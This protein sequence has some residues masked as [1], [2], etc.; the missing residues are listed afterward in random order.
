MKSVIRRALSRLHAYRRAFLL[1]LIWLGTTTLCVYLD[2]G[3]QLRSAEQIALGERFEAYSDYY[4][5]LRS[6]AKKQ[7]VLVPMSDESFDPD[8]GKLEGPP[9]SRDKHAKVV[10]DLVRAGAKAVVFDMVFDSAKS[11]DE[12]GQFFDAVRESKR[13][14]WGCLYENPNAPHFVGPHARFAKSGAKVGHIDQHLTRGR[15]DTM[16]A[17]EAPLVDGKPTKPIASLSLHGA[18]LIAKTSDFSGLALDENGEFRITFW[19]DANAASGHDFFPSV[20]YEDV[21]A[22]IDNDRFLHERQ[23]FKD[24]IVIIGDVTTLG[25]DFRNTPIADQM[26]GMEIQ[27]HATVTVLAALQK[28]ARPI[29]DAPN[30]INILAIALGAALACRIVGAWRW[31]P[32]VPGL[33]VVLLVFGAFNVWL[34]AAHSL[35]VHIISPALAVALAALFTF[36]ERAMLEEREKNRVTGHWQRHVDPEVARFILKYPDQLAMGELRDA[37]VLF[38]DIR[39]FTRLS[40]ELPP[41][42]TLLLLNEYLG[43]MTGVVKRHGGTLDKYVGD[44]VMAVFGLPMPYPDHALRAVQAA[45]EM[46]SAFAALRARWQDE[47]WHER[48]LPDFDIGIGINTGGM[49]CGELGGGEGAHRRSDFTVIGD[50]VNVAAHIESLTKEFKTRLLIGEAT[51]EATREWIE[52]RGP[53]KAVIKHGRSIAVFDE[54]RLRAEPGTAPKASPKPTPS[55]Q[56]S[57]AGAKISRPSS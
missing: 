43:T 1:A 48:G 38:A 28:G 11:G 6:W 17:F 44:A 57:K 21:L 30:W 4:G 13:V 42:Q 9:V 26:A 5:D 34:F 18:G 16:R 49:L 36:A 46:Q 56:S 8:G 25:N 54:V 47:S 51:F 12:D 22:G 40:S 10:R 24:K 29:Q 23:F 39:G 35:L 37:T 15:V 45:S 52:A 41:G 53:L 2:E 31:G 7:V 20:P 50:T 14:V 55:P 27:A 3:P 19:K 32:T 33:V